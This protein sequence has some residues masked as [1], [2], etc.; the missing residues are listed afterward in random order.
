MQPSRER[1]RKD[2][3]L[4]WGTTLEGASWPGFKIELGGS[5]GEYWVG[6]TINR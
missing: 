4:R 3:T 1:E 2:K 6:Q 5:S